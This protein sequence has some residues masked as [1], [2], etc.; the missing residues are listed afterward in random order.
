MLLKHNSTHSMNSSISGNEYDP[1]D[2]SANPLKMLVFGINIRKK[3][4]QKKGNPEKYVEKEE[5]LGG[6]GF[7]QPGD[8]LIPQAI[9]FFLYSVCPALLYVPLL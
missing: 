3:R 9:F 8:L 7:M 1:G 6:L 2:S 5:R 4:S